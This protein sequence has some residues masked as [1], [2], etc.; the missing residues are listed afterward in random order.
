MQEERKKKG[1]NAAPEEDNQEEEADAGLGGIY[2]IQVAE[3]QD[4]ADAFDDEIGRKLKKK[5][6]KKNK[7]KDN[8]TKDEKKKAK[9]DRRERKRLNRL[10]GDATGHGDDY[11]GTEPA[12]DDDAADGVAGTTID[13][14]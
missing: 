5:K 1:G 8:L 6:D 10:G 3:A 12:D 4:E 14:P 7:D 9:A 11:N 13:L 2:R